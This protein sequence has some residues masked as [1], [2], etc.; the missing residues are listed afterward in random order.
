LKKIKLLDNV[1]DKMT[2]EARKDRSSRYDNRKYFPLLTNIIL[3]KSRPKLFSKIIYDG[4]SDNIE[5]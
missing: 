5:E 2:N 4:N 3:D 1:I